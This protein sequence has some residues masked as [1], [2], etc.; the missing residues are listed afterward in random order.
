MLV[1]NG[2][3]VKFSPL[4]F[5]HPKC[6][7]HNFIM[8]NDLKEKDD[9]LKKELGVFARKLLCNSKCFEREMNIVLKDLVNFHG[10]KQCLCVVLIRVIIMCT[11]VKL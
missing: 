10:G 4:I 6:S 11:H 2:G 9:A 8:P 1:I 7:I 3:K 5:H